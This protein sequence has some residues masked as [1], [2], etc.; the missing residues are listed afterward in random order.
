MDTLPGDR[1]AF[2]EATR[3]IMGSHSRRAY[4][5]GDA[6]RVRLDR[7]DPIER[8]LQFALVNAGAAERRRGKRKT[9]G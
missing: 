7:A 4:S 8:K 9:R 5:I 3:Q 2:H 6:V 1:F